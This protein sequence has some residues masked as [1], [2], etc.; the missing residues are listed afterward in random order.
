[1]F[2]QVVQTSGVEKGF[3]SWVPLIM[4]GLGFFG[5]L[6]TLLLVILL[7]PLL[8]QGINVSPLA[9]GLGCPFLSKWI[10]AGRVSSTEVTAGCLFWGLTWED[11]VVI[12][13]KKKLNREEKGIWKLIFH[14]L[15]PFPGAQGLKRNPGASLRNSQWLKL[16]LSWQEK[17]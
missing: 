3:Q 2:W 12:A 14:P 13:R 8:V 9:Q 5:G 16:E 4:R 11:P 7:S 17:K 6:S 15:F 1:M 10:S